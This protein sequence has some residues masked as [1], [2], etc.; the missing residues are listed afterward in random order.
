MEVGSWKLEV[1][2]PSAL[3]VSSADLEGQRAAGAAQVI[4]QFPFAPA[5]ARYPTPAL[6][7]SHGVIAMSRF[8]C[9]SKMK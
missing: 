5:I 1:D 8:A 4:V 3:S 6:T 9:G 2:L 7:R